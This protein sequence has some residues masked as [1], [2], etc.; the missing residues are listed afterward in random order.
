MSDE[1]L[2]Q[3]IASNAKAIEALSAALAAERKERQKVDREWEKDR[4]Q[5]YQYLGRIASAQS[6]F[7]EVQA[8]YYH[9]LAEL[10]ERQTRIL[11]ELSERQTTI[12]EKLVA[13]LKQVTSQN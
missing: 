1:E 8:D 7:Y 6:G 10:S 12:E 11:A 3:L 4:H 13:I 5:L 2:K 9:Q